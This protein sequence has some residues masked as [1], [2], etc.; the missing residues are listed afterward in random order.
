MSGEQLTT[1]L[2]LGTAALIGLVTVIL[3]LRGGRRPAH[4]SGIVRGYPS[5]H[6]PARELTSQGPL[7]ELAAIQERLLTIYDQTPA[8]SDLAV[9]LR[10]FLHELREIMDTAYRV[11][12]IARLYGKPVQIERLVAEVRR[13]EAEL[14]EHVVGR[15]LARDGD[16]EQELLEGRLAT[17]RMCVRELTANSE[18][19]RG[20][21]LS[22]S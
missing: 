21:G 20:T 4:R 12:M 16:R 13:I 11:G 10:T 5:E 3:L 19:R 8:H 18:G 17:L 22:Q 6:F 2:G 7:A 14:A 15:L 1:L 9:W